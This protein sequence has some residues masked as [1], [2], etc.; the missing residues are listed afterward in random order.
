LERKNILIFFG[1]EIASLQGT[2]TV[3]IVSARFQLQISGQ[4]GA[5]TEP[6]GNCQSNDVKYFTR[7]MASRLTHDVMANN[8][9]NFLLSLTTNELQK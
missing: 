2:S 9:E 7:S 4:D 5:I 1:I 6:V 3:P 8:Y